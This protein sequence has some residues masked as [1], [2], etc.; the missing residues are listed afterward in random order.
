MAN[1]STTFGIELLLEQLCCWRAAVLFFGRA[2]NRGGSF[3]SSPYVAS[4]RPSPYSR[5][6]PLTWILLIALAI[7]GPL[8]VMQLP[9]A[10]YDANLHKF[11]ASHYAQHWFNPW[12]EKWFA[13]FSQ[14][15]YPPL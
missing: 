4:G 7:H 11:F 14:T 15:T 3:M 2:Q 5:A 6:I 1:P 10:S 9:N 13:G 12:N 8:L